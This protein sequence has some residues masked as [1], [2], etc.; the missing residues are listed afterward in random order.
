MISICGPNGSGKTTILEAI[1]WTLFDHLD[2][3]REDF[4]R[5]G[6]KKGQA[7]VGFVS[8]LDE[9]EYLVTRDTGGT[10]FVYDPQTRSRLVEQK[11]Q[12]LPWLRQRLGVE[13]GTDL[14]VLFR[15]TIGVP[16]GTFTY[17]FTLPPANRK[18][19]FDQIL[20]VEDYRQA[21]DQLRAPQRLAESRT[22][23]LER[24]LSRYEGELA[25]W[26]EMQRDYDAAVA[27]SSRLAADLAAARAGR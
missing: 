21:A 17:D 1:A 14:A 22:I 12:V 4:V 26:D 5:R 27:L 15:T 9:R 19:I 2:Y 13:P 7:T 8:D 10:Y 16:Q 11:S 24:Q 25:V 20:R 23:E 6:A 18:A 3:K